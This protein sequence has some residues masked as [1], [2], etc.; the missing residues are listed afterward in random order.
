M[1]IRRSS[2][3]IVCCDGRGALPIVQQ[4][5]Y[6]IASPRRTAATVSTRKG[7]RYV[8]KAIK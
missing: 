3:H 5:V 2:T 4:R 7:L 1:I 8:W 6:A